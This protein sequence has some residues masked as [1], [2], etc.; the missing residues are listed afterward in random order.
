MITENTKEQPTEYIQGTDTKKLSRCKYYNYLGMQ[1]PE[2]IKE[3]NRIFK[4]KGCQQAVNDYCGQMLEN[5]EL[6]D[7]P[8]YSDF[9]IETYI[10]N[11][12]LLSEVDKIYKETGDVKAVENHCRQMLENLE[13]FR[14]C[15]N[16]KSLKE[17]K[18][19]LAIEADKIFNEKW[20]V[21]AVNDFCKQ[22]LGKID[23]QKQIDK[24]KQEAKINKRF[25]RRTFETYKPRNKEQTI[26]KR[27]AI[28]Y[29][30][31]INENLETGKNLIFEGLGC[32]GTGKTHLAVA[33]VQKVMDKF[34]VPAKF[35]NILDMMKDIKKENYN[36]A[37]FIT[38]DLLLIDDLGK[39]NSCEWVCEQIYDIINARYEQMKPTIITTEGTIKDLEN[40]YNKK[41]KAIISRLLEKLILITL[42][43]EDYRKIRP[44]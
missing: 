31:N 38:V 33:V 1:K 13:L 29:A 18:P 28:A 16:Y 44:K 7:L 21:R 14:L 9:Y 25:I 22:M 2:L 17:K 32:V 12:Q 35:I 11:P 43:G 19:K 39:E 23:K 41:G 27:Q 10:D 40:K 8:N 15:P 36:N 5:K 26:G 30:D 34:V 37:E 4:E 3:A 42:T 6:F 20:D 24:I